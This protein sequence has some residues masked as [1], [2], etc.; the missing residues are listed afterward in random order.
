MMP[1]TPQGWMT[2]ALC[3]TTAPEVFFPDKGTNSTEARA[4]CRRCPVADLCLTYAQE[5][6]PQFGV[7]AGYSVRQLA[8]MRK[9]AA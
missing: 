3:T 1:S 8:Q 5:L 6:K 4:I 9:G 2:D 7:W